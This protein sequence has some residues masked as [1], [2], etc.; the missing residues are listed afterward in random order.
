MPSMPVLPRERDGVQY[1]WPE[2]AAKL[3][4]TKCNFCQKR[5]GQ[6]VD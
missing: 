1:M 3:F 5:C 4:Y 2:E 6:R